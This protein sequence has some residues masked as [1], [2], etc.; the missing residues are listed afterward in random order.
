MIN[1][2]TNQMGRVR[3]RCLRATA[4]VVLPSALAVALAC[5]PSEAQTDSEKLARI[6]AMVDEIRSDFP[7]VPGVT[8]DELSGLLD[9]AAVVLVDAREPR[10]RAV[11]IIPG[12][13]AREEFDADRTAF[14]ERRVVVY[15]TIGRRSAEYVEELRESGVDAWNLTGSI[16]AWT[17]ADGPLV[18]GDE[19]TRRVHVYGPR[20]DLAASGYE[21]VW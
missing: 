15:C 9:S 1:R 19:P 2:P 20:W 14:L 17:H 10:E 18:S 5:A 3:T 6:H 8:P 4:M 16:V 11:S 21:T 7:D 13:I 12:A